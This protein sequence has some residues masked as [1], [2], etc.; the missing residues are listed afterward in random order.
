MT[1]AVLHE[2]NKISLFGMEVNPGLISAFV[3]TG[4][5]FIVALDMKW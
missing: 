3:I 1:D 2:T 4:I 5:L